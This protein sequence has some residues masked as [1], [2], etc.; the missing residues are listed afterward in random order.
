MNIDYIHKT[1]YI[2]DIY[3]ASNKIFFF[4]HKSDGKECVMHDLLLGTQ[5]ILFSSTN[6]TSDLIV[7]KNLKHIAF[8]ENGLKLFDFLTGEVKLLSSQKIVPV[9][10]TH[11]GNF[12]ICIRKG[13]TTKVIKM[14]L[15]GDDYHTLIELDGFIG[16]SEGSVIYKGIPTYKNLITCKDQ[17]IFICI[18]HCNAA[19]NSKLGVYKK[20]STGYSCIFEYPLPYTRIGFPTLSK[21]D[22]N[23]VVFNCN[24]TGYSKLYKLDLLDNIVKQITYGDNDERGFY[25]RNDNVF[26]EIIDHRTS[27]SNIKCLDIKSGKTVDILFRE[28]VNIPLMND[29]ENIY[30]INESYNEVPDIWRKNK[31]GGKDVRIT[32]T[33]PYIAE[34]QI[35]NIIMDIHYLT[36]DPSVSMK[37][38]RSV[39][40]DEKRP[41][42]IWLHG[43]PS[44]YS[45]N[46]FVPFECWLASLNYIVCVPNYHGTLGYGVDYVIRAIGSGLG[47]K[48]LEDSITVLNYCCT[49]D[50]VDSQRTAA[51]GVSYGAYLALRMAAKLPD[52]KAVFVFGAITN[53]RWQQTMTDV[54]NYDLWLLEGWVNQ[55]N[56]DDKSPVY[57]I[58]N[59]KVP[60][61]ITHGALD[62][63]VPFVQ[64]KEYIEK[65]KELALNHIQC[66]IYENEG[67]GLPRYKKQNY[68]HWHQ[69]LKHFLGFHL[70]DWNIYDVPYD[71]QNFFGGNQD[72]S[73]FNPMVFK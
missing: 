53:W 49:L 67:H 21:V 36:S 71:N 9:E 59:I 46:Q 61:F 69:L 55:K 64:I 42:L 11:D 35:Q 13:K 2:S 60:V 32:H 30:Y 23:T 18:T 31:T 65:S 34:Q 20:C 50:Y 15:D 1:A 14:S 25:C 7:D 72:E 12:V 56:F 52:M 63:N 54:R 10:F 51:A 66:H 41:L 57:E 70:K 40:C 28:G 29:A 47:V 3:V 68:Y 62:V 24:E 22:D 16:D 44:I 48:D 4:S 17:D 8:Y 43:G 26:Y 37:I 45:L 39:D 58:E 38:Y 19:T 5:Q 6:S 27:S 73:C 33:A